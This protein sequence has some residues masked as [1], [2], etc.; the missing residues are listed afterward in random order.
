[1]RYPYMSAPIRPSLASSSRFAAL[2]RCRSNSLASLPSLDLMGH[3]LDRG[4][5]INLLIYPSLFSE[6]ASL[7]RV[8]L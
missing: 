1:V 3:I 5:D 2:A 8:I 4:Q 6:N 7:G